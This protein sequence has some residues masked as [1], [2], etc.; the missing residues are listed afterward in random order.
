MGIFQGPQSQLKELLKAYSQDV[1]IIFIGDPGI[2]QVRT[3]RQSYEQDV[4][5]LFNIPSPDGDKQL[6]K[7]YGSLTRDFEKAIPCRIS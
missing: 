3:L 2:D 6:V 4:T 5:S 7:D 1:Q